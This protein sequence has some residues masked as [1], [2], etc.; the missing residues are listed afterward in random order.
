SGR[1]PCQ[2]TF[3]DH[4]FVVRFQNG[5]LFMGTYTVDPT[6]KPGLM[7]MTI[8]EGPEHFK[9]LTAL[10][11]YDLDG[12]QLHWCPNEPGSSNRYDA[13]PKESEG[14]HPTLHFRRDGL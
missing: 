10:C 11:L 12:E 13:F 4:N 5:D 3:A 1:W 8:E 9:G 2:L 6:H 14:K 7:E